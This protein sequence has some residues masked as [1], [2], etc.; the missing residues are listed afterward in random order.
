MINGM[1]TKD[2]TLMMKQSALLKLLQIIKNT[3]KQFLQSNPP[4]SITCSPPIT[5]VKVGW[6][7]DSLF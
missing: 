5:D 7:P 1:T 4:A 3:L 6:I 2:R